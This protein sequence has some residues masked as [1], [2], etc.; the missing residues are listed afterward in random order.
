MCSAK[1]PGLLVPHT[2]YAMPLPGEDTQKNEEKNTTKQVLQNILRSRLPVSASS[3]IVCELKIYIL[4]KLN[5]VHQLLC[6]QYQL[7]NMMFIFN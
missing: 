2:L 4:F 3:T 5:S 1:E 7:I 6:H